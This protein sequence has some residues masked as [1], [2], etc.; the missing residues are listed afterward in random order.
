MIKSVAA[1]T[2]AVVGALVTVVEAF[3]GF[4]V[5]LALAVVLVVVAWAATVSDGRDSGGV[6]ALSP[7]Q[8][9]EQRSA[10]TS[11][12]VLLLKGF[13]KRVLQ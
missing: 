6:L 3:G 1:S 5:T 4:D 9:G 7:E 2:A 12:K 8:A 13:T 10:E 11:T